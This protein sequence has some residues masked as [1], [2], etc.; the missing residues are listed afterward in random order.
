MTEAHGLSRKVGG[1]STVPTVALRSVK[2]KG[3]KGHCGCA[4]SACDFQGPMYVHV[5]RTA[6]HP[7]SPQSQQ[8]EKHHLLL[9][10]L[11]RVS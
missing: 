10:H 6:L 7:T 1:A 8:N 5:G 9:S 4:Q 2:E 11:A 3:E